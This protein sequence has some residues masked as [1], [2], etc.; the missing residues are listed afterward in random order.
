MPDML[1]QAID[2]SGS[3]SALRTTPEL[4]AVPDIIIF[5]KVFGVN[6]VISDGLTAVGYVEGRDGVCPPKA[7]G[8]IKKYSAAPVRI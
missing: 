4:D 6:Q 8:K 5:P 3:F 7:Q 2:E 1:I